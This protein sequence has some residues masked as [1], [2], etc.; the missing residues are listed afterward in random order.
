MNKIIEKKMLDFSNE[1]TSLSETLFHNAN[2]YIGVRGTLEEGVPDSYDTMRGMYING[3][4]DIIPMK[5][6]ENLCNFV[7]E[8]ETMLNVADT[9]TIE[10]YADGERFSHFSGKTLSGKRI[11]NMEDGITERTVIW[12]SETGKKLNI[13]I[14]RMTSFHELSLFTIEYAVTAENFSGELEFKSYHKPT[15]RNY[16]NPTDPRLAAESH[17]HLKD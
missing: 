17:D 6:A 5:Q 13:D 10:V 11:L 15:V 14:K 8:K 9:Q 2:G 4:Y 3:F 1:E 7:E 12:E 16:C